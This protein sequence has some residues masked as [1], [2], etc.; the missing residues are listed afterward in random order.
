MTTSR[1][2][3]APSRPAPAPPVNY[4]ASPT[5]RARRT[6]AR[7]QTI[8]DNIL[9]IVE[10]YFPVTVRQVFYQLVGRAVIDK[11][12]AEYKQTVCRL[13][14]EM[15][16]DGS[17]EYGH[18]A[19]N[20]RWQRKPRTHRSLRA[21]LETSQRFYRRDVWADQDAY[22]EVWLE[23]EAL[24]GVLYDVTEEWDVPLMV[25]R[26]YPSLSFLHSAGESIAEVEKPVFLYYFGDHDPSGVDISRKVE[27]EIRQFAPDSEITFER[28]AVTPEQIDELSLP[29]RPTKKSDSRSRTFEGESVEVD[30][31]LPPELKE[32][33]K[34]CIIQ[35]IDA[36]VLNRMADVE[37]AERN[38]LAQMIDTLGAA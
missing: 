4:G 24:S 1:Q 9:E 36:D 8:R 15:R 28:V 30:A 2:N 26:G 37:A 16:R 21:F 7:I 14:V 5:K 32:M 10:A 20:T 27:E 3:P 19:D 12:E 23:K 18:I 35:H 38:T 34:R 13:L 29:T 31:I 25:T 22:V 17:I 11:T 6:K 33:C